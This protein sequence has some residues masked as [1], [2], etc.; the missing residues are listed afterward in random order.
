MFKIVYDPNF[1]NSNLSLT[2]GI[3]DK[4]YFDNNYAFNDGAFY[5]TTDADKRVCYDCAKIKDPQILNILDFITAGNDL[6]KQLDKLNI[7]LTQLRKQIAVYD[8]NAY[9]C[10]LCKVKKAYKHI[11][12]TRRGFLCKNCNIGYFGGGQF[13]YEDKIYTME[14]AL[15]LIKMKAFI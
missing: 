10:P 5:I 4:C 2:P 13:I 11:Y 14:Q 1:D 7:G 3:F 12:G 8:K 6:N 15:K 9:K